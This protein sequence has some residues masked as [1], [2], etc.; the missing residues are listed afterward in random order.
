MLNLQKQRFTTGKRMSNLRLG[1]LLIAFLLAF[2]LGGCNSSKEDN[3]ITQ[4]KELAQKYFD[5]LKANNTK[6]V[7]ECYLPSEKNKMDAEYGLLGFAGKLIFNVD[8]SELLSDLNTLFGAESGFE[9]YK[10]RAIDAVV[11]KEWNE[12]TAYVEVYELNNEYRGCVQIN[13]TEYDGKWY[14]VKGTIADSDHPR[15]EVSDLPAAEPADSRQISIIGIVIIFAA[16]ASVISAILILC[17][18]K[19]KTKSNANIPYLE[20]VSG[21]ADFGDVFC[22]YCASSNPI[23][24]R[25]CLTCGKKL[26]NKRK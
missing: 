2:T 4:I 9:N 16:G 12:A 20:S 24:V 17:L 25:T 15:K 18:K 3:E 23:G 26:K 7:Y 6:G 19:A 10:Y 8:I 5:A 14:V 1:V 13:L 11:D 22:P 21:A